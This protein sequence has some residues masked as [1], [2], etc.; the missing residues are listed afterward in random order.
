MGVNFP[1]FISN[2]TAALERG[3]TW[4]LTPRILHAT[5][6]YLIPTAE[7]RARKREDVEITLSSKW[8]GLWA[9][10]RPVLGP[11]RFRINASSVLWE[12]RM[13]N[14]ATVPIRDID[15]FLEV[16]N[17]VTKGHYAQDMEAAKADLH[18]RIV[19]KNTVEE[20]QAKGEN[21]DGGFSLEVRRDFVNYTL[22]YQNKIESVKIVEFPSG[23]EF[24]R[25]TEKHTCIITVGNRVISVTFT[26]NWRIDWIEDSEGS[27]NTVHAMESSLEYLRGYLDLRL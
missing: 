12:L 19:L 10:I 23:K 14:W 3:D 13:R 27:L 6:D 7:D 16:F 5:P 24:T 17:R 9:L 1:A 2:A 11:S 4:I 22:F 25:Q 18:F 21:K 15:R 26:P 8:T 20:I